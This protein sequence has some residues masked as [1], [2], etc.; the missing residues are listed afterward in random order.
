MT[1]EVLRTYRFRC[2]AA[3]CTVSDLSETDDA[4][5]GWTTIDSIAHQ[6]HAPLPSVKAGRTLLRALDVRSLRSHG[7]FRLHLCPTHVG[8]LGKHA[9]QTDNEGGQGAS[10]ACSCGERLAR[11]TPNPKALWAQHY[12]AVS[13]GTEGER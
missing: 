12:E 11:S 2:D 13:T 9:P 4:P 10:V 3:N 6:S 5:V 1:A 8:A 7:R